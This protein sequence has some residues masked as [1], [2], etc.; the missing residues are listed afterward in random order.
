MNNDIPQPSSTPTYMR[1]P[2]ETANFLEEELDIVGLSILLRGI[3]VRWT[4]FERRRERLKL[5]GETFKLYLS[6]YNR[7]LSDI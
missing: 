4:H 3:L 5:E 2:P 1:L 6:D 7:E